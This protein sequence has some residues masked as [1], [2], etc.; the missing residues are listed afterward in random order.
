[1][2]E[3]R[4]APVVGQ[5]FWRRDVRF[6][7]HL[8]EVGVNNE[9][10]GGERHTQRSSMQLGSSGLPTYLR[11]IAH[12]HHHYLLDQRRRRVISKGW[13]DSLTALISMLK[14]QAFL[15]SGKNSYFIIKTAARNPANIWILFTHTE[16]ELMQSNATL[17][18]SYC[19]SLTVPACYYF[20]PS[21]VQELVHAHK[22]YKL[23]PGIQKHPLWCW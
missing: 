2:T 22:I 6:S 23:C 4:A 1:M 21:P 15:F 17:I 13:S 7:L 20:F 18:L 14:L 3:R 5:E 10:K 19:N 12:Q 16:K 8:E 11:T 9:R